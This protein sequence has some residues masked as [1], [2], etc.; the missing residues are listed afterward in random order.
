[1]VGGRVPPTDESVMPIMRAAWKLSGEDFVGTTVGHEEKLAKG[2][3]N[4]GIWFQ[5]GNNY[6]IKN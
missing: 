4:Q 1:M 3:E 2:A 6:D 5:S